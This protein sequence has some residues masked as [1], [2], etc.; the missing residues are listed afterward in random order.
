[1]VTEIAATTAPVILTGA[2]PAV[3]TGT[4]PKT[5]LIFFARRFVSETLIIHCQMT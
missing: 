4:P 2:I 3:P 5:V 1:M